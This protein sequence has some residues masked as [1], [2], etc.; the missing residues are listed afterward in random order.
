MST[1]TKNLKLFKPELSDVADITKMNPNWDKID[2]EIKGLTNK[3]TNIEDKILDPTSTPSLVVQPYNLVDNGYYYIQ[4]FKRSDTSD[5][6][7]STVIYWWRNDRKIRLKMTDD[8]NFVVDINGNMS[9]IKGSVMTNQYAI[10]VSKL[11]I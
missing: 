8:V 10:Y 11:N 3:L 1:T 5:V 7:L 4:V 6:V 9:C 2:S